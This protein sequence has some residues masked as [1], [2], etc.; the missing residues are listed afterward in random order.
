MVALNTRLSITATDVTGQKAV[1]VRNLMPE[2]T[3]GELVTGLIPRMQLP[4]EAEGRP[5]SY[6]ARLDRLGRHLAASEKV[7]QALQENDEVMLSPSID[8]G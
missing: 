5:L 3:V 6:S 2:S 7:G 1:R 4:V 8:A